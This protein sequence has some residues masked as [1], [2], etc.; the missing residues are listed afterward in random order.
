MKQFYTPLALDSD[1]ELARLE[2]VAGTNA[3]LRGG[4]QVCQFTASVAT[5][6]APGLGSAP[7]GDGGL[8]DRRPLGGCDRDWVLRRG[9]PVVVLATYG[10]P[11]ADAPRQGAHDD[12]HGGRRPPNTHANGNELAMSFK[13]TARGIP[14]HA[15]FRG[16]A[17][18]TDPGRP[19]EHEGMCIWG[20]GGRRR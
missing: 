11:I 13:I 6:A 20:E 12:Q 4:R 1:A 19:V 5:A 2:H 9:E 16:L 7:R 10:P 14:M 18:S 8:Y 17:E 3:V 15:I